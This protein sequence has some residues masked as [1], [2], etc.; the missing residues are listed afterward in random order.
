[1]YS[2]QNPLKGLNKWS[3]PV[4]DTHLHFWNEKLIPFFFK[5]A[6]HYF[7]DYSVVSM[8][9]PEMIP[10][11]PEEFRDKVT[12]AQFFRING[13]STQF[14]GVTPDLIWP[15]SDPESEFGERSYDNAIPWRKITKAK[16]E[17]FQGGLSED[18]L[19]SAR[20]QHVD[21]IKNNPEFRY[22]MEVSDINRVRREIKAVTLNEVARRSER[23]V[24]DQERLDL[25]NRKRLAMGEEIFADIDALEEFDK[26]EQ[27][28]TESDQQPDAFVLE[29][30]RILG[31]IIHFAGLNQSA[32]SNL[33]ERS[34]PA[35]VLN[36]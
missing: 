23:G 24:R 15:T 1:M 4:I 5:W 29:S 31:D 36:N 21:R 9:L 27:N 25:E 18:I 10:K 33:V 35:Q 16:F 12:I 11:I 28:S 3:H 32:D 20:T 17:Q 6:H 30:A 13:D 8:M 26:A 19:E 34:D 2:F 22:Y 14:R 7:E